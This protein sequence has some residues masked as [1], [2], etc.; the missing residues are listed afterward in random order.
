MKQTLLTAEIY[1]AYH[2]DIFRYVKS[3]VKDEATSEDI[4]QDI[5]IKIHLKHGTVEDKSKIKSWVY[6]IARNTVNDYFKK[7]KFCELADNHELAET[8]VEKLNTDFEKC[9]Y[10]LMK[11]LPAEYKN[12]LQMTL[13]GNVS[14]KN[15]AEKSGISYSGI[16]SR[17]Q[18]A[19]QKL[20]NEFRRCCGF[21]TDVYGN[22]LDNSCK[23]PC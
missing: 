13:T 8:P 19:K 2:K 12:V 5:F 23:T 16:K 14:Q 15:L 22:V 7:Q 17:I 6:T 4:V 10:P 21:T 20:L 3:K 1:N 11:K 9:L 18:R